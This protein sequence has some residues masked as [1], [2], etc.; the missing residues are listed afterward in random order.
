MKKILVVEDEI[1]VAD[2]LYL[3]LSKLGFEV[4]EPALNYTEAIDLIKQFKPDFAILD[5]HLGGKLTGIDVAQYLKTHHPIPFV[6]LTAFS[7]N[8]ILN[9]AKATLPHG[10]LIKPYS[11]VEL[12]PAIQIA[13]MNHDL[14]GKHEKSLDLSLFSS[15]E[16]KILNLIANH[17]SS[18][19]IAD[20]VFLSL[21]TIKNYRHKICE[22]LQLAQTNNSLLSWVMLHQEELKAL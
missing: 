12:L 21:S 13:R 3:S 17:R 2:D 10:Y 1:V 7:D 8:E 18:K 15:T 9:K 4:A 14:R 5:I 19:Q 11:M 6:F 22:K 16:I 20:E